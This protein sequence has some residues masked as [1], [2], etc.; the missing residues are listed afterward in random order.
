MLKQL[1]RV[2]D[3]VDVLCI[4]DQLRFGCITPAIREKII[5]FGQ[6][7]KMVVVDSRDRIKEFKNVMLKPNEIEGYRAVYGTTIPDDR[8]KNKMQ[9]I[10][11]IMS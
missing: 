5:S 6:K 11:H 3:Q 4:S 8:S 7:G 2:I 10:V 9:T 1:D